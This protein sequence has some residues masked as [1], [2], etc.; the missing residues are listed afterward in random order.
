MPPTSLP[1]A[2]ILAEGVAVFRKDA[3]RFVIR[4]APLM[5]IPTLV[6]AVRQATGDYWLNLLLW[7]LSLILAGYAMW[8][9]SR[10]VLSA[11]SAR[12]VTPPPRDDWW[13]RDGFVRTS[14]AFFLT[15]AVGI[16]F[17][18][19]PGF[20]VAMI[21]GLYP[22]LIIERRARG[23]QALALSSDLTRGNRIRLLRLQLVCLL[24]FAPGGACL[25]LWSSN[26]LGMVAFW[27]VGTPA[28]A[29]AFSTMAV[30]YRKLAD[31]P[32]R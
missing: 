15:V 20:M 29:A 30:A 7:L 31:R 4:A 22:F 13:V 1:I 10:S 16:V 6:I 23:F 12:A 27:A 14:V 11:V 19:V 26:P 21:Y 9:L 2:A 5:A 17:L 18:V 28:L 32:A 3:G 8:P 25:Y 24:L